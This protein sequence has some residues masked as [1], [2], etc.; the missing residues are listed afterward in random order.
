MTEQKVQERKRLQHDRLM[1]EYPGRQGRPSFPGF[2]CKH[3]TIEG[4]LAKDCI[5]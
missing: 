2:M 4:K 1:V 5:H 3:S